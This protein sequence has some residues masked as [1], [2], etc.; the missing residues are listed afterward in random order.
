VKKHPIKNQGI[1]LLVKEYK[2]VFR[3]PENLKFYSE[4]DYKIAERKFIKYAI[5]SGKTYHNKD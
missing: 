5:R 2:R 4:K 3:I 1:R